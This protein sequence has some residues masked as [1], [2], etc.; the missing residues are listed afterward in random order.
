VP[1][2]QRFFVPEPGTEASI[3]LI[4]L[5]KNFHLTGMSLR[6]H[7][8]KATLKGKV[9]KMQSNQQTHDMAKH[10]EV[11]VSTPMGTWPTEGFFEVP[12]DQK[13][14]LQ[15]KHVASSLHIEDTEGWVA[16]V[17][18]RELDPADSYRKNHLSERV[19]IYYGPKPE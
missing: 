12:V 1:Y 2:L 13:V 18:G 3:F 7:G 15:L 10:I 19:S 8:E 16:V 11:S 4:S 14:D 9:I 5:E 17:N 6:M